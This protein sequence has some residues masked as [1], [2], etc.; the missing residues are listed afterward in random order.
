M[1]GGQPQDR[2]RSSRAEIVLK[3]E[4]AHPSELLNDYITNLG[5][6]GI[7]IYTDIPFQIGQEISFSLSFPGLL[8]PI[9]LTGI[10]RWRRASDLESPEEDAGLGVEFKFENE[11]QRHRVLNLIS[12]ISADAP[13]L[14]KEQSHPFRVLLV[15]DNEFVQE[16]FDY[17]IRRF[18]NEQIQQGALEIL[19]ANS[20]KEGLQRIGEGT[21]HLA[22]VDHFLP[23]MTGCELVRLIR[24]EKSNNQIPVLVISVGGETVRRQAYEAGAD[25]YLDKPVLH[26]QLISTLATLLKLHHGKAIGR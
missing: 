26:K 19:L 15:E 4:Y 14:P 3:V 21:I 16:L 22:I 1:T 11:E 12:S 7:F 6:G 8:V 2:R 23:G 25:L 18:Y 17:A 10:V 13:V 20:A 9:G 24:R 5:E